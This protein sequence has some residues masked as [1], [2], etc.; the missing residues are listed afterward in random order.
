MNRDRK[1]FV[2]FLVAIAVF[3]ILV[4]VLV[5]AVDAQA[6]AMYW[7]SS[8]WGNQTT[9]GAVEQ[10]HFHDWT[11]GTRPDFIFLYITGPKTNI[12]G[13]PDTWDQHYSVTNVFPD[14]WILPLGPGTDIREKWIYWPVTDDMWEGNSSV[15]AIGYTIQIGALDR[16]VYRVNHFMAAQYGTN[17]VTENVGYA[18]FTCEHDLWEY[19]TYLPKI[20]K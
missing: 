5:T 16:G 18:D 8:P 10:I 7:W 20:W 15:G 1:A 11:S 3:L 2:Y 4:G 9:C 13:P 19:N 14:G 12:P 6:L 17:Q